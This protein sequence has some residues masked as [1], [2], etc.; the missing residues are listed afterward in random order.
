MN[1]TSEQRVDVNKYINEDK[2]LIFGYTP[3]C[4]TC[5]ISERMLDIAN[6]ILKLPTIKMDLNFH[7]DFSQSYEIQSVPVLLVMS[8]G[9]EQKRIYAFQSVPYLLE[10]LK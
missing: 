3:T 8:K 1:V 2:Y 6:D 7:P 9:E 4:G 10:N 5:K